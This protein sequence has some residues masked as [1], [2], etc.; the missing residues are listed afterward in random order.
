[1]IPSWNNSGVLPPIRPGEAGHSSDRSP[2]VVKLHRVVEHFATSSERFDILLGLLN[3][4]RELHRAGLT[5]G[6]QWL[7]GSFMEQIEVAASRPPEDI[8]V[9][10]F[11][12]LPDGVSQIALFAQHESL[13][14]PVLTKAQFHVDGYPYILGEPMAHHHVKQLAYWYS[15]WS[16]RRTGLWKGFLQVDL[17]PEEDVE[18]EN[19]LALLRQEGGRP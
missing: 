4:R 18:A 9:V 17:S 8:D 13:F 15:L 14:R 2:Y 19:V 6:F 7:D 5:R 10:S 11:F 16:H 1:M 3:Y 12:Y